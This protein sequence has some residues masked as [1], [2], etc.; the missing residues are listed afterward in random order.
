[1]PN[2]KHPPPHL[3]LLGLVLAV[4]W[5]EVG[6]DVPT[7]AGHVDQGPLLPQ[8]EPGRH[9]QHQSDGLNHQGPLPQVAPDDEPT[10]DCLD[11]GGRE[12][13]REKR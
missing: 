3:S 4:L 5:E 12:E 1:M 9:R 7:A 11:L 2:I 10:Q 8:A 13:R 6:E